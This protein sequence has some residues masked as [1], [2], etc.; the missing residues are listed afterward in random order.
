MYTLNLSFSKLQIF[1]YIK[2]NRKNKKNGVEDTDG[3]SASSGGTEIVPTQVPDIGTGNLNL[4]EL[5]KHLDNMSKVKSW[6]FTILE[7]CHIERLLE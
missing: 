2:K 4:R 1:L 7:W 6:F 5:K 3:A